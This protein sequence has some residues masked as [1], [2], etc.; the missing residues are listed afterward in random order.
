MVYH[1]NCSRAPS[2]YFL[3]YRCKFLNVAS[4]CLNQW[5]LN[6]NICTSRPTKKERK[7]K[8]YILV[9]GRRCFESLT[10]NTWWPSSW[11][12][13]T[14]GR[15]SFCWIWKKYNYSPRVSHTILP[16]TPSFG[17][18][19]KFETKFEMLKFV[20]AVFWCWTQ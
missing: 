14:V 9:K 4:C 12:A 15:L 17:H 19:L 10:N 5:R 18:F 3:D 13:S 7:K 11:L 16:A 2:L 1:T 6:C 8:V 20:D